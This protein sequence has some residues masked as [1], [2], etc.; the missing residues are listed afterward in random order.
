ME[1]I[2]EHNSSEIQNKNKTVNLIERTGERL[3]FSPFLLFLEKMKDKQC[4]SVF[5][6]VNLPGIISLIFGIYYAQSHNSRKQKQ[7]I[8]VSA[9]KGSR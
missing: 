6:H 7:C 9:D 4:P 2:S 8:L 3:M 1:E 5:C